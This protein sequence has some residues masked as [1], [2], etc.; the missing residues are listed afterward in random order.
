MSNRTK[1]AQNSNSAHLALPAAARRG[2]DRVLDRRQRSGYVQSGM[3]MTA[4]AAASVAAAGNG[5]GPPNAEPVSSMG[6]AKP[7][8]CP[9][10]ADHSI[11]GNFDIVLGK[12]VVAL[13]GSLVFPTMG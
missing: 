11:P 6:F 9:S 1:V 5:N 10:R 7:D 4:S 8:D 3:V 12:Y 2:D 13:L